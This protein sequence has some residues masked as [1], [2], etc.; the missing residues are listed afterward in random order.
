MSVK[1]TGNRVLLEIK[2]HESKTKGGVI[3]PDTASKDR[4]HEGKVIAVGPGKVDKHGKH[5]PIDV[6]VGNTVYFSEYAGTEVEIEGK[7][8]LLIKD[9]ELLAVSE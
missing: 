4:P 3:L 6:K 1:P 7:K 8:H 9:D 2:T 5:V